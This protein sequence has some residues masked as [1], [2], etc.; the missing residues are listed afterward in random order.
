MSR[1]KRDKYNSKNVILL[2]K[3][4]KE[5]EKEVDKDKKDDKKDGND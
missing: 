1:K 2:Q 4:I 5:K 3:L